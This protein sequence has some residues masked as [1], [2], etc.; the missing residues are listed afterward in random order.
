MEIS[1]KKISHIRFSFETQ[2]KIEGGKK[3]LEFPLIVIGNTAWFGGLSPKSRLFFS[4]FLS[5]TLA[6]HRTAGKGRESSLFLSATS[7]CSRTFRHLLATLH[8]RWM[9]R[10]CNRMACNYQSD[11]RWNAPPY[12]ITFWLTDDGMLSSVR[13]LENLILGFYYS[14]F[15]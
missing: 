1:T 7:T 10:I 6:I 15:T 2:F 12:L 14:N 4:F 9:P 5:Q 13:W 8:V 11:T 3:C